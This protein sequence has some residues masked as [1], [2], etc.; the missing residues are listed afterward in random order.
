MRMSSIPYS[1]VESKEQKSKNQRILSVVYSLKSSLHLFFLL[2]LYTTSCARILSFFLFA[3][4]NC[5]ASMILHTDIFELKEKSRKRQ[6]CSFKD[7]VTSFLLLVYFMNQFPP[8]LEYSIKTVS[9]FFKECKISAKTA[10]D[11]CTYSILVPNCS[12]LFIL[13]FLLSGIYRRTKITNMVHLRVEY[14]LILTVAGFVFYCTKMF[15]M[16]SEHFFIPQNGS[17]QNYQVLNVFLI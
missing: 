14:C 16:N 7:S 4:Q 12:I 1:P 13:T 2:L 11:I 15:G 5:L 8:A 3:S 17:E 10:Y 6:I 9:N